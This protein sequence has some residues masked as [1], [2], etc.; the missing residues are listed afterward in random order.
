MNPQYIILLVLS[1]GWL[2]V[3]VWAIRLLRIG[4]I[5]RGWPTAQGQVISLLVKT[6]SKGRT[7]SYIPTINYRYRVE[8]REYEGSR[9]DATMSHRSFTQRGAAKALEGYFPLRPVVVYYN[10]GQP[11][12]SVLKPGVSRGLW[13]V[14]GSLIFGEMAFVGFWITF[15]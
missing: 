9:I 12:D 14:V 7:T 10:P 13:I 5:S 1:L 15:S 6:D 8:D 4:L 2:G 11:D 3:L